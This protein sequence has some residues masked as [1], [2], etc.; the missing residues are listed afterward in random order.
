MPFVSTKDNGGVPDPR[1]NTDRSKTR[2]KTLTKRAVR[3]KELLTILRKIKPHLS[4]SIAT[5]AR[6][7]RDPKASEASQL[8]AA[9][10]LLNAYKEL[11]GDI[12][13]GKEEEDETPVQEV[14]PQ[15]AVVSFKMVK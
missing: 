2:S 5:A 13:D 8:K 6:I 11:V 14:Q 3:D 10:I 12:Y 9:V 15:G 1:I 7:M 4:E